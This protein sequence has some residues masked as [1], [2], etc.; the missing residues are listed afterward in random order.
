MG[1]GEGP[2]AKIFEST[3]LGDPGLHVSEYLWFV[4]EFFQMFRVRFGP[5]NSCKVTA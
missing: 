1:M 4:W 3:A 2:T 5:R